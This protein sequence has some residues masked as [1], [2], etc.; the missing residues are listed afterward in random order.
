MKIVRNFCLIYTALVALAIAVNVII[1]LSTQYGIRSGTGCNFYDALLIGIEC[2]DF[3]GAK[4][5]ELF[6]NLPLLLLYM[7]WFSFL[8]FWFILPT[9]LLWFP[10]TFL[11]G[12]Y[13]RRQYKSSLL[14]CE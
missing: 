2:R 12:S 14:K 6:L 11:V 3:M 4:L 9:L 1:S 5:I 13:L 7:L 10:P 8:S